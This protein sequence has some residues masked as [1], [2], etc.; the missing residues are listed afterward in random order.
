LK[1]V[2]KYLESIG[3][4][5]LILDRHKQRIANWVRRAPWS[6]HLLQMGWRRFGQPWITVGALGAV[7]NEAGQVLIVEHVFHPHHPWGLPGGWMNRNETP[8]QT[9]IR[10]LR[11]ETALT[12]VIDKPLIITNSALM[13][14][15]LDVAFLCH[16]LPGSVTLSGELL[17]YCWSDPQHLPPMVTFHQAVI[18]AALAARESTIIPDKTKVN[19]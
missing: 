14:N 1:C 13:P 2:E 18:K 19:L 11:E 5:A 16:A 6:M 17:D 3:K 9:V 15:H 8:D 10:E 12:V 7:F 4:S